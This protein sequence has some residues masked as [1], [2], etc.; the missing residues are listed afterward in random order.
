[1]LS[2]ILRRDP[3]WLLSTT[4]EHERIAAA[5]EAGDEDAAEREIVEH[6]EH[7]KAFVLDSQPAPS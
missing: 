3:E 5:V 7:G 4:A 1:M 2:I 6:L